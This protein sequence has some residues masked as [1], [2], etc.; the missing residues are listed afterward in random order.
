MAEITYR[1]L[2]LAGPPAFDEEARRFAREIQKTL[3]V[4][5]MADPFMPE[6]QELT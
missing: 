5:P 2:E 4:E 6:I 3:G 1:N